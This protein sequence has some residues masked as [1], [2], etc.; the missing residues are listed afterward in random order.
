MEIK[1]EK[2]HIDKEEFDEVLFEILRTI[3]RN[4]ATQENVPPYIIFGDKTLKEMCIHYPNTPEKM[5][6]IS[7]VGKNKL[8]K[9]G[10][11]FMEEIKKHIKQMQ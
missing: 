9:Y 5:L 2:V 11:Q 10:Q 7:G 3:R 6:E 4:L 8:E 1:K